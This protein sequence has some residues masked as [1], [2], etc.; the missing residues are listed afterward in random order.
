MIAF[1][2]PFDDA[3]V[4]R[5]QV[6]FVLSQSISVYILT[7]SKSMFE[8]ISKGCRTSNKRTIS[9]ICAA[10]QACRAQEASNIG[11]VRSSHNLADG[12]TNPKVLAVL[13]H[14]LTPVYHKQ[15]LTQWTIR[16]LK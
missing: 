6:K 4:I 5:K 7:D 12:L 16:D 10:K 13:Y 14:L 3:L 15:R 8:I 11:F 2:D 9:D 1:A